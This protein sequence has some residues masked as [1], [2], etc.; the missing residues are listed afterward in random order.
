MENLKR[1]GFVGADAAIVLPYDPKTDRVLLIEQFR[2]GPFLRDDP[3]PWMMEPIAGRID[4]N[5]EPEQ[6]AYRESLEEAGI[7][8]Y[9]I[10]K[11]HSGYASPGANTEYFHIFVG[12]AAI[13]KNSGILGGLASESEDIKGHVMSFEKFFAMLQA[14]ELPVSP[15]ALAGYWLA[16]NRPRLR[17]I[18]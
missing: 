8:L 13:E 15:L 2:F 16:N 11:V 7:V 9:D 12:L 1:S 6:T 3:N 18:S 4:L 14:G 17:G 10:L 5:E